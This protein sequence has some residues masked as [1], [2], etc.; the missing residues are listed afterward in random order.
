MNFNLPYMKIGTVPMT[1]VQQADDLIKNFESN[2]RYNFELKNWLRL[3]SYNNPENFQLVDLVGA[4]LVN[5]VLDY[6]PDHVLFGWSVSHLPAK[7]DIIDHTDRM[8]F[9]RF[10]KRII[11][12]TSENQDVLNWHWSS[13]R[14]TKRPYV[15]ERANIYRLNTAVTHG[16]RNFDNIDRR[17]VYFDIMPTRLYERFH[18]HPDI[19]KVILTNAT[20]EKYVL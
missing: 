11:V 4:D 12:I 18:S 7:S 5:T 17:G 10:A 20:G 9:H 13:D 6:F 2:N 8:M 3:D 19:L 15:F 14:K 1:V 16:V